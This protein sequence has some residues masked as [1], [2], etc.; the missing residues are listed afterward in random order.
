MCCRLAQAQLPDWHD[1]V[2][3]QAEAL[4]TMCLLSGHSIKLCISSST[5][6][7]FHSADI[8]ITTNTTSNFSST[9]LV[10]A[11]MAGRQDCQP[12]PNSPN[13]RH[14]CCLGSFSVS[15]S[16]LHDCIYSLRD[17][18][19]CIAQPNTTL[20]DCI[21]Y[22]VQYLYDPGIS[23]SSA[24]QCITMHLCTWLLA[25]GACCFYPRRF[26]VWPFAV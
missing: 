5:V 18:R 20:L 26:R 12:C 4:T 9:C 23:P 19:Q 13:R 8:G 16:T 15:D 11:L 3:H 10:L 24:N 25:F 22:L 17:A 1:A 6:R 21:L 2:R 7:A 14:D